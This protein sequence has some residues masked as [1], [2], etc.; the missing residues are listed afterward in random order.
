VTRALLR[1]NTR[2]FLSVRKYRNYRLFFLGQSVSLPGTWIQRAAQAWL[3]LT[4]THSALAVGM[5]AFA[6]F[7]P[8]TLFSLVAGVVVDR[9]DS[10]KI[11]KATQTAFMVIAAALAAVTLSGVVEP[12]EVYVAALLGGLVQVIDSPARQQLTYRMVGRDTL[13]NAVALNSSVFNASR[14]Y[15]PGLAGV[16][17]AAFGVGIC[18]AINAVSF[19]A[20]LAGLIMMRPSEFFP[21][22]ASRRPRLIGGIREGLS[23]VYRSRE[24][25]LVLGLVLVIATMSLNFNVLLPVL[26]RQTLHSHSITFGLLSASFGFGALAGGLVAA[27]QGR[28]RRSF[29]LIGAVG[30]GGSQVLLAAERSI[31]LSCLLLVLAGVSFTT[32]SSNSN[33]IVQLS[34]PDHLRG[35]VLGLYL[36]AYAGTGSF[37]G[38]FAG[39][40]VHVGGTTLA[41]LVSGLA[42]LAGTAVVARLLIREHAGRRPLTLARE[43]VAGLRFSTRP[44]SHPPSRP[45]PPVESFTAAVRSPK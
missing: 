18:F 23:Y 10:H 9:L 13:Q 31:W 45:M 43:R 1:F 25:V 36:F 40:L 5:L 34:A 7:L 19:L 28:A 38:L 44:S 39:W 30:F 4:L 2:A 3:I 15:G 41:F 32:W 26:A 16:L 21:I 37:G 17:I 22:E 20:V 42:A 24:L 35:R 14:I 29:M 27:G 12:W 6:Q 33:S 11:V 8:F